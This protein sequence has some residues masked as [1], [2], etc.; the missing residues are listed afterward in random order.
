[1]SSTA[2]S[3]G[4]RSA[5]G[6]RASGPYATSTVAF[7]QPEEMQLSFAGERICAKLRKLEVEA[8]QRLLEM[9]V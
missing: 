7:D 8:Q 1:M 6:S 9:G 3:K 2:Q 5:S 4:P